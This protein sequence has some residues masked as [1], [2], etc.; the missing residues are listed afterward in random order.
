MGTGKAAERHGVQPLSWET[1]ITHAVQVT[2]PGAVE[3]HRQQ[4]RELH[5]RDGTVTAL[6]SP[7]KTPVTAR[8]SN[9]PV[10]DGISQAWKNRFKGSV[11]DAEALGS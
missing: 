1:G 5:R 11:A 2:H 9:L 4:P 6:E 8:G 7:Q 10:G 3:G